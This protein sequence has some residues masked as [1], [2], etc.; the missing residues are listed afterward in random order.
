MERVGVNRRRS[1]KREAG[2]SLI[3]YA[4]LVALISLVGLAGIRAMGNKSF[5][6]LDK[7]ANDGF[8]AGTVLFP[9]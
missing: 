9:D 7:T 3:E 5:D 1:V 2:A 8:A 6:A 4:L